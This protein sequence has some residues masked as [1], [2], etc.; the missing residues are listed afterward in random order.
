MGRG[1]ESTG[2]SERFDRS[3]R[4]A[5]GTGSRAPAGRERLRKALAEL[6]VAVK[7]RKV[8]PIVAAY[9]TL[10]DS[11][12]G[13][14]PKNIMEL[15]IHALGPE[16]RD[17]IVSAYSQRECFM[18]TRGQAPCDH[19]AG[20]GT[21]EDGEACAN[22]GGTGV[23]ACDFC[24]GTGW[25]DRETIPDE[26][27]DIVVQ[28][29]LSQVHKDLAR[30]ARAVK[31]LGTRNLRRLP[32]KHRRELAVWLAQMQARLRDLCELETVTETQVRQLEDAA[33]R[34]SSLQKL[35]MQG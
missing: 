3:G 12:N 2:P 28:R 4:D 27:R 7:S 21:D 25:A 34:V 22:C 24:R 32:D 8:D 29:Q 23:A 26:I 16:A 30:L 10:H 6:R 11:A 18:C 20:N 19:C 9:Q 33:A 35:T 17:A 1:G 15:A 13:V 14:S 5:R 31:A